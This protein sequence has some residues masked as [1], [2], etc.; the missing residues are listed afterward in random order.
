M[1]ESSFQRSHHSSKKLSMAYLCQLSQIFRVFP[2]EEGGRRGG[3]PQHQKNISKFTVGIEMF[4]MFQ[5]FGSTQENNR[6]SS[7]LAFPRRKV[8]IG[9]IEMEF[10]KPRIVTRRV[11][12]IF[13]SF[14]RFI[15]PSLSLSLFWE[16][17]RFKVIHRIARGY[18]Y[19]YE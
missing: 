4:I 17:K 11:T 13:L 9:L 1:A 2:F 3:G 19:S 16:S 12:R 7:Q 8:N 14:F 15:S 5:R 18:D 10:G 6:R